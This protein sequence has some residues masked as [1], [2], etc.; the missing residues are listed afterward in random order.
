MP[1]LS[2]MSGNS[3]LIALAEEESLRAAQCQ[4]AA[5]HKGNEDAA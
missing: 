1:A 5:L 4:T 2:T 3:G